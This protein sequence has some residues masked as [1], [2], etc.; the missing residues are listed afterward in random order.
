[1][2][3]LAVNNLRSGQGESHRYEFLAELAR[4]GVEL[5]VR[6][7]NDGHTLAEAM[8][9][10]RR[11]DRVVTIGGDGTAS[12]A[13]YALRGTR[14]PLLI[15]PAGTANA[16]A[17][18]LGVQPDP[19]RCA[20]MLLNGDVAELDLGEI[21]FLKEHRTPSG[22][23]RR[24][25]SRPRP[26][27]SMGFTTIAGAGLDATVVERGAELKPQFGAGAY[28]LAALQNM[29][30]KTARIVLDMDGKRVET[31][32][33]GILLVNFG[34]IQF[35]LTVTH[36]SDAQDGMVE[37]VVI[38]AKHL[39]ELI[40]AVI[41]SYLD[42]IVTYPSRSQVIDTYRA[43]RLT[44]R[45]DPPLPIQCDGEVLP[46]TTPLRCRVL[47]RAATLIVPRGVGLPGV[48]DT[49]RMRKDR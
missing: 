30:P 23:E 41:A 38:K 24:A 39:A 25:R 21:A 14:V 34:R 17:L 1:M 36:D 2:R 5:T 32:G 15:Y 49:R 4:R 12:A 42:R 19:L 26:S 37:V 46:G 10:A 31:E 35:D 18:N 16:L 7:V 6:P 29:E 8:S 20:D 33:S 27:V 13:A 47:H 9:D 43:R 48:A 22:S 3:V 28:L 45:S 44:V 11:F 40:P